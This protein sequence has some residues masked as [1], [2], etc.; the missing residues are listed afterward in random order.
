M[1]KLLK[2]LRIRKMYSNINQANLKIETKALTKI[3]F[4][5]FVLCVYTH[6]IGCVMWFLLKTDYHWVAPTDFGVLR[7]RLQDPWY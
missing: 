3:F 5:S 6:V 2:V 4:F 1:C 7:S